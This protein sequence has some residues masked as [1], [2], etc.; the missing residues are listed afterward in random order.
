[1]DRC[2]TCGFDPATVAPSDAAV[3]ARSFPRRYRE[4]LERRDEEEVPAAAF[5]HAARAMEAM[6]HAASSLRPGL[7]VGGDDLGAAAVALADAVDRLPVEEWDGPRGD[8]AKEAIHLGIHHL[9]AAEAAVS[10]R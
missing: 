8:T 1:M 5:E 4:V 2:P 3:A 10:D 6:A 7:P 9:R